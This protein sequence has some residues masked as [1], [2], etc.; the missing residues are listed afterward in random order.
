MILHDRPTLTVFADASAHPKAKVAGWGAWAK[1]DDRK[2]I[3]VGGPVR[4]S[5]HMHVIELWALA[6]CLQELE[7]DYL[8]DTDRTVILQSDNL[9]TLRVILKSMRNAYPA[10]A[11]KGDSRVS[12]ARRTNPEEKEPMDII[13]RIFGHRNVVYLRHIKSHQNGV[14]TRSG[15]NEACDRR[16][17]QEMRSQLSK[18]E[19][20][21]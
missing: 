18:K 15:V 6:L 2:S 21:E 11:K 8:R 19:A 12:P 5:K 10:K 14:H 16:A 17:K 4:H 3:T 13:R 1:G 9:Q 20:A 7:K